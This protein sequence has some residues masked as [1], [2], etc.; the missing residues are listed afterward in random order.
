MA[1]RDLLNGTVILDQQFKN[2]ISLAMPEAL[3]MLLGELGKVFFQPA[4]GQFLPSPEADE[5][6]RVVA[7]RPGLTNA[8]IQQRA[9]A[10]KAAIVDAYGA[11]QNMPAPVNVFRPVP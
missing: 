3:G 9:D 7:A 10:L 2:I 11:Y 1:D 6:C 8:Q 5:I 4:G